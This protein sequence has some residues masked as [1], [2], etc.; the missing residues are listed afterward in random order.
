M[1]KW[2]SLQ[3]C[4]CKMKYYYIYKSVRILREVSLYMKLNVLHIYTLLIFLGSL[5]VKVPEK[6]RKTLSLNAA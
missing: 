4:D 2:Q 6:E 5:P 3:N 1:C